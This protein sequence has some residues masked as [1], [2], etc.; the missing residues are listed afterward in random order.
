MRIATLESRLNIAS[1]RRELRYT[2]VRLRLRTWARSWVTVFEALLK[3]TEAAELRLRKLQ[4]AA[5]DAQ[6]E[7]DEADLA[8]DQLVMYVSKLL[9]TELHG[10][11]LERLQQALFGSERPSDFVKPKLGAELEQVRS[12][13]MVLGGSAVAKVAALAAPVD[14]VL[15]RCDDAVKAEIA[16]QAALRAFYIATLEPLLRKINGERQALGGEAKK[17]VLS[18]SAADSGEGLFRVGDR[19]RAARL[20][21]L[22]AAAADVS[23]AEQELKLAKDRLAVLQAE[24]LHSA[25]AEAEHQKKLQALVELK[26]SQAET[27]AKLAALE[28]DL[29][30]ASRY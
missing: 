21:T 5:E 11:A 13:P 6:A 24:Q 9:R 14:A 28:A 17:Q 22:A 4:D 18:G 3:D 26:R 20:E 19:P 23:E 27:A 2:L 10:V 1:W 12:W 25:E 16:A 30:T 7:L 8:L 29:K 15:K